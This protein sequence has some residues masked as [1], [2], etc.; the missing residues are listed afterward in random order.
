M[1]YPIVRTE[2]K[3]VSYITSKWKAPTINHEN[4]LEREYSRIFN[5]PI[6]LAFECGYSVSSWTDTTL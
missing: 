3:E 2:S 1:S 6:P 4:L 5:F